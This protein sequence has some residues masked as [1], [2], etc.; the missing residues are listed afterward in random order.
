MRHT[1]AVLIS[2]LATLFLGAALLLILPGDFSERAIWLTMC[3]PV[4]WTSLILYS[5][6]D[7]KALRATGVLCS[8]TIASAAIVFTAPL[9]L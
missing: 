9:P 6:W 7:K 5:Y 8:V 4:I 2:I 1:S 3:V